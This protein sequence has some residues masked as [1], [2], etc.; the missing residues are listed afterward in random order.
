MKNL[1]L[2]FTNELPPKPDTTYTVL[3]M[4]PSGKP[5]FIIAEFETDGWRWYDL[6]R[7]RWMDN[8]IAW[9]RHPSDD[10][11]AEWLRVNCEL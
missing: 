1:I 11:L 2:E 4:T 10:V 8:V 9:A 3:V 7:F 5:F 6:E